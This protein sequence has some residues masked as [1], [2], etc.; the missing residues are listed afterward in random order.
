MRRHALEREPEI[1]RR[2]E[3]P[4]GVLFETA[5]D[6]ANEGGGNV[7]SCNWKLSGR[8]LQDRGHRIDRCRTRKRTLPRQQLYRM[9]PNEKMSA[10]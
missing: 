7:T 6:D 5:I 2:L 3:T 1:A 8:F 9:T 10:R 4:G